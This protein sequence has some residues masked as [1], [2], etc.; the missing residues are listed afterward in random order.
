MAGGARRAG[1][2]ES[3]MR[4]ARALFISRG[5]VSGFL[6]GATAQEARAVDALLGAELEPGE[7]HEGSA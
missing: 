6:G 7:A 3:V 4:R 2:S 1:P 5:V